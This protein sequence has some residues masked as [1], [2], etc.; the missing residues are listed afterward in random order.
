MTCP[1]SCF[2]KV[3]KE[4]VLVFGNPT[5]GYDQKSMICFAAMHAGIINNDQE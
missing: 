5:D 1:T 3:K 4:K 2:S